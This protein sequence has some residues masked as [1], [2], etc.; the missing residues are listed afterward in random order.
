[1]LLMVYGDQVLRVPF[2][3]SYSLNP[4]YAPDTCGGQGI[5]TVSPAGE[6]TQ[7]P[8]GKN[9]A[10]LQRGLPGLALLVL[11]VAAILGA[12]LISRYARRS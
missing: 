12:N 3:V 8:A 9:A 7:S 10:D 2:T 6:A 11:V 4:E 5:G 1:M